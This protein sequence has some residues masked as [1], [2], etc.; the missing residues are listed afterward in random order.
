MILEQ[1]ISHSE[2]CEE[3]GLDPARFV[4]L[5]H[6]RRGGPITVITETEDAPHAQ[7]TFAI[8]PRCDTAGLTWSNQSNSTRGL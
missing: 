4:G 5:R 8:S 1:R 6:D 3:M 7:N 2:F